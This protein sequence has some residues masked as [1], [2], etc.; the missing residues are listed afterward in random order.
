MPIGDR[1]PA[2][3]SLGR[4]AYLHYRYWW[5]WWHWG[6]VGVH[7]PGRGRDVTQFVE[8]RRLRSHRR[9]TAAGYAGG[10][11]RSARSSASTWAVSSD[12]RAAFLA[13]AVRRPRW[14]VPS[15]TARAT[16]HK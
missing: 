2:R 7:L 16:S 9:P 15:D 1:E 11:P 6:A 14:Q 8:Q 4:W 12:S 5:H 13:C 3:R 10:R